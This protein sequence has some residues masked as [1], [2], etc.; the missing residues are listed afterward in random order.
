MKG[1][2]C[3]EKRGSHGCVREVLAKRGMDLSFF[4]AKRAHV[5]DFTSP[6]FISPPNLRDPYLCAAPNLL[7]VPTVQYKEL[8]DRQSILAR[9]MPLNWP[10]GHTQAF[11]SG[12]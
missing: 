9:H 5:T 3:V 2:A 7:P 12:C 8:L 11:L 4:L 1:A 10:I 6:R